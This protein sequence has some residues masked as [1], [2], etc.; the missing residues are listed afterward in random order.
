ME[1]SDEYSP[2]V[3]IRGLGVEFKSLRPLFK[4]V[5]SRIFSRHGV[6]KYVLSVTFIGDEDMA[7]LNRNSLGREGPTDV[8]AFDLSEEGLP[9]E[10]VGDV[11]IS[12]ETARANSRRFNVSLEEELLRLVIHGALHVLGYADRSSAERR[13]MEALQEEMVQEFSGGLGR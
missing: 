10:K 11:Y 13:K 2:S 4:Q 8:I 7:G 3:H 5:A 9:F 1:E 6:G 12:L